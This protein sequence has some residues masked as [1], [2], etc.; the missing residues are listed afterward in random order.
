MAL[1]MLREQLAALEALPGQVTALQAEVTELRARAEQNS[2]NSSKP[3]SSDFPGSRPPAS[4]TPTR[5]KRGGQPGH[6]GH[7][8]TLLPPEQV[9]AVVECWPAHCATCAEPLSPGPATA[10]MQRHQVAELPVVRPHVT[11]YRLRRCHCSRCG[12]PTWGALPPGT[13]TRRLGPRFQAVLALLAGRFRLSKRNIQ[14]LCT[15]LFGF[16]LSPGTIS[17]VEA[18][19]MAALETPYLAVGRAV[20]RSPS[21]H[22]DE[23]SWL[24]GF[25]TRWLWVAGTAQ[26][27]FYRVDR[28]RSREAFQALLPTAP[29]QYVHSDRYSAYAHL[30]PEQRGI[31]WSHLGRD[32]A[33]L[34]L[35][36]GR[37][38]VYGRWGEEIA[39][40][41]FANWG[42][43]RA[44]EIDRAGLQAAVEPHQRSLAVLLTLGAECGCAKTERFCREVAKV[45][46]G[47]WTFAT[48]AGVEPTNNHA[49]RLLRGAVLWRKQSYGTQSERGQRFVE[50]ILTVVGTLRLQKRNVLEYLEAA[51]RARLAGVAAPTII[52]DPAT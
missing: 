17:A 50:R 1:A 9:G 23:T 45:W 36:G 35:R 8:R 32:F 43:F 21:V 31:C 7:S 10:R 13:P 18:D 37:A 47:L 11:E 3:P 41:V 2:R 12:R 26:A 34:A 46:E 6:R 44:G 5:R 52:P 28:R 30:P 42:R 49:E 15:D 14:A 22:V 19:T 40:A 51:C 25:K 38:Q 4:P 16:P 33:G 24:E 20:A 48:V 29:Y 39:T 27:V